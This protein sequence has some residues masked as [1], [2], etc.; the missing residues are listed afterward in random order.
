MAGTL[1]HDPR[2]RRGHRGRQTA[3]FLAAPRTRPRPRDFPARLNDQDSASPA[4]PDCTLLDSGPASEEVSGVLAESDDF[5]RR[6]GSWRSPPCRQCGKQVSNT[7]T[8]DRWS[9]GEGS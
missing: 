3:S 7:V 4:A 8:L 5:E 2:V 9:T 1:L 6:D